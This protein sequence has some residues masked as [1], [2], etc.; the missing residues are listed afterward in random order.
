M[1]AKETETV[2]IAHHEQRKVDVFDEIR[3]EEN[4]I[5]K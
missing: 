4:T 1:R 3:V 5:Q 2:E